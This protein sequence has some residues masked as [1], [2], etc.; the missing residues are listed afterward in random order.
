[1]FFVPV[2]PAGVGMGHLGSK[3]RAL[4][5]AALGVALRK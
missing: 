5:V 2:L 1:M 3:G 4:V